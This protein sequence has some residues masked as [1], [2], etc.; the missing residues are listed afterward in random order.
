LSRSRGASRLKRRMSCVMRRKEGARS[1]AAGRSSREG[2]AVFEA[3]VVE[4]DGERHVEQ[5]WSHAEMVE[6]ATRLG[7]CARCSTMKPTRRRA[8][9]R[10]GLPR[11]IDRA[12]MAAEPARRARRSRRRARRLS[13][14]GA[15]AKTCTRRADD[16]TFILL[17]PA[18]DTRIRY[19]GAGGWIMGSAGPPARLM[20]LPDREASGS[21][22]DFMSCA[23]LRAVRR[24]YR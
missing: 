10:S 17:T 1:C 19:A 9:A 21:L 14:H 8:S 2:A 18:S 23:R 5:A 24:G 7:S 15:R 6:Q 12:G 13:S 4:A 16:G 3:A 11:R 20:V 22:H